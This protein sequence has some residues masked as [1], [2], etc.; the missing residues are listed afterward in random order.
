MVVSNLITAPEVQMPTDEF[1]TSSEAARRLNVSPRTI[2]RWVRQGL[3]S[4]AFP[5]NPHAEKSPYLIPVSAIEAFEEK[6]Q[7]GM[8]EEPDEE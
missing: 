1:I 7:K 6:R 2:T 8:I 4:G 3:F 5:L